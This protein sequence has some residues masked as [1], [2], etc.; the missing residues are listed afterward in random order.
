MLTRMKF[1]PDRVRAWIEADDI[2]ALAKYLMS[3]THHGKPG[4]PQAVKL[5]VIGLLRECSPARQ[6]VWAKKLMVREENIARSIACGLVASGWERDRKGTEKRLRALVED[7]DWEVREWASGGLAEVLAQDFEGG[8]QLCDAWSMQADEAPCRAAA[9]ALSS[10]AKSRNLAEAGP[11]LEIIERLLSLDGAYLQKN[12]GPFA[13]GGGLLSRFPKE[14]LALLRKA[15][16]K[17]DENT[18]WNVAMAFT[19]AA[20]RKHADE[21]R[22]ILD[23]L[24]PDD[25]KRIV[26]AVAKARKNLSGS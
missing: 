8:I 6:L 5:G 3:G 10:Q 16:K 22:K 23:T 19:T 9:L 7:D 25:R 20:A 26:H 2:D 13:L 11:M 17:R 21:G 4:A 14:T 1:D 12:L 18:R 24:E 15:S